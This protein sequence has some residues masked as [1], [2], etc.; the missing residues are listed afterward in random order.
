MDE[1]K[2]LRVLRALLAVAEQVDEHLYQEWVELFDEATDMVNELSITCDN[3]DVE[4][5]D[6]NDE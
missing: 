3:D 2:V 1:A 5:L 6:F 4:E